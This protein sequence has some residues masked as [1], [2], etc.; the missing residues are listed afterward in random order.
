MNKRILICSFLCVSFLCSCFNPFLIAE[1]GYDIEKAAGRGMASVS[2]YAAAN[3]SLEDI[4]SSFVKAKKKVT[5]DDTYRLVYGKSLREAGPTGDTG[6]KFTTIK[7]GTFLFQKMLTAKELPNAGHYILTSIDTEIKN[8]YIIVAIVYRPYDTIKVIDKY[9]KATIRV[10]TSEDR[11]FYEPFKTD[12]NGNVLDT[13]V[14]WAGVP[15]SIFSQQ[16]YRA[17]LLTQAAN[18]VFEKASHDDYWE[19]EQRWLAGQ[20]GAIC[21]E[22]DEKTC[23]VMGLKKGFVR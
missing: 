6:Y 2:Y 5:L 21:E 17:V 12:A 4:N 14:D 8:G 19:A 10:F 23:D 9:D 3:T 7:N 15:M 20:A 13:I 18:Q 22:Q 1:V 16:R 11:G